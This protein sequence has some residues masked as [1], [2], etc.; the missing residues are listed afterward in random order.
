MLTVEDKY[1]SYFCGKRFAV[2]ICVIA[3]AAALAFHE[4]CENAREDPERSYI[5]LPT[6]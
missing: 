2:T 1:Q 4:D 3:Q 6:T 5:S